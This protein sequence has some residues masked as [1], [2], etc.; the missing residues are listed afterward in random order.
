MLMF[1]LHRSSDE[2]LTAW[3]TS[4]DWSDP[5]GSWTPLKRISIRKEGDRWR[6]LT[7]PNLPR[8]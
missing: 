3:A 2:F 8:I 6:H 5:S 7:A 1:N 4:C